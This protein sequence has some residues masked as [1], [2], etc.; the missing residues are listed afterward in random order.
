MFTRPVTLHQTPFEFEVRPGMSLSAVA[1]EL[2][3]A[4]V[5]AQAW[6]MIALARLQGVDRA[7]KAGSY[8]IDSAIT[9][10]ELLAR[11]TQ[12]DVTQAA[13]TIIQGMPVADV[14]PPLRA[15]GPAT[16]P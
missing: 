1:H 9:L 7:I 3:G 11:L 10:R 2:Q 16:N 14:N 8:E 6:P 15:Q 12:R 5:L 4:N 13:F